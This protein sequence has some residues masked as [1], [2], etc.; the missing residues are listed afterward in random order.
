VR[1]PPSKNFA[2]ERPKGAKAGKNDVKFIAGD[3]Y[4]DG[5]KVGEHLLR[6]AVQAG[7]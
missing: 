2:Q 1:I 7:E 4:L 5:K 3:V 6:G